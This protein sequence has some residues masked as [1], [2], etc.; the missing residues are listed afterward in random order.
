MRKT[1]IIAGVIASLVGL[2]W[3]WLGRLPLG[4]LPGDILLERGNFRLYLPLTLSLTGLEEFR[5]LPQ[6]LPA[7]GGGRAE[8]SR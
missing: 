2:F 1:L 8:S 7:L 3:P 6:Y 4:R 5:R